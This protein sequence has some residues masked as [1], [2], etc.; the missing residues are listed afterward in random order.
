MSTSIPRLDPSVKYVTIG[1]LRKI[2]ETEMKSNV[3]VIQSEEE[4]QA[5]LMPFETYLSIQKQLDQPKPD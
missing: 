3:Y 1:K 2:D 4:P 5:V